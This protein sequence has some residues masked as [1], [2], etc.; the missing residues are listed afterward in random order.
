M[1]KNKKNGQNAPVWIKHVHVYTGMK[2]SGTQGPVQIVC[3]SKSKI[4]NGGG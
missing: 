3:M 1:Y 2:T 4:E